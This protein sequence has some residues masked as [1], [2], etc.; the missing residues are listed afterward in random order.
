MAQTKTKGTRRKALHCEKCEGYGRRADHKETDKCALHCE[1]CFQEGSY[2]FHK[3]KDKCYSFCSHCYRNGHHMSLCYKLKVCNLCGKAGHNPYRCWK[4]ST[5]TKW[6]NRVIDLGICLNCLRPWKPKEYYP[7][8]CYHCWGQD[9][10]DIAK[11]ITHYAGLQKTN[12]SQT[13]ENSYIVQESQIE[14]QQGKATC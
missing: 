10:Q 5:I 14:L 3:E 2:P 6:I 9:I 7:R 12:E 13:E 4:Y 11:T 1:E 8:F